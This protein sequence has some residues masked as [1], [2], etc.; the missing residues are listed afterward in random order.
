MTDEGRELTE[1]ELA[2]VLGGSTDP[3]DP[4]GNET[5]GGDE[6]N[7]KAAPILF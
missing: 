6:T 5:G 4:V 3:N 1:T 7:L 2:H